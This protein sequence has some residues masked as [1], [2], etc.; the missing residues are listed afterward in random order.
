MFN[1]IDQHK[2]YRRVSMP[3]VRISKHVVRPSGHLRHNIYSSLHPL[4]IASV[5]AKFIIAYCIPAILLQ[6][7]MIAIN[8]TSEAI[9]GDNYVVNVQA[10]VQLLMMVYGICL[11]FAFRKINDHMAF[12]NTAMIVDK[13]EINELTL[14]AM[15]KPNADK[16]NE[17][18]MMDKYRKR[19]NKFILF[20][21]V[22]ELAVEEQYY[23]RAMKS[24]NEKVRRVAEY[25]HQQ[26]NLNKKAS[27]HRAAKE[28]ANLKQQ[29]YGG[30]NE[31]EAMVKRYKNRTVPFVKEIIDNM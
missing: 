16:N 10:S 1:K 21:S 14:A 23:A 20:P 30:E 13:A 2:R 19:Y 18:D 15:Y 25:R 4:F 11:I 12:Y 8:S 3:D 24:G 31:Y 5:Y 29:K 28:I 7:I 17:L 26:L 9:L 6:I 22:K 27:A